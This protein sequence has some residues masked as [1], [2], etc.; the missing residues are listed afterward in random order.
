MR[1][2]SR[3]D[4]DDGQ[5]VWLET[6]LQAH[7]FNTLQA[8]ELLYERIRQVL[9]E[10][11]PVPAVLTCFHRVLLL[12]FRGRYQDPLSADR[13]KLVAM[14]SERV[15]PFRVS[16]ETALLNGGDQC[17]NHACGTP[18]VLVKRGGHRPRW[19]VVGA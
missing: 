7:F 14:L 6:P 2:L 8:G 13:E 16:P 9:H 18:P 10:P 19:G 15:A 12:G 5:K 3:E 11:A 17:A 1:P 4:P